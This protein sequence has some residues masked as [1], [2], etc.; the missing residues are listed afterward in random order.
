MHWRTTVPG[1][2]KG[3]R[4]RR[5]LKKKQQQLKQQK[6]FSL[7]ILY[8]KRRRRIVWETNSKLNEQIKNN[9]KK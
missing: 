8:Y 5:N 6:H 7:Y 2:Q 1:N 4:Y 9:E 3:K